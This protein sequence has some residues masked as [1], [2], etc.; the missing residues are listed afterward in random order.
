[1]AE[2]VE[3][4][5]EELNVDLKVAYI[6]GDDIKDDLVSFQA[7]GEEIGRAHV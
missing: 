1:M 2:E 5:L 3:K 6:D 7:D 4:I